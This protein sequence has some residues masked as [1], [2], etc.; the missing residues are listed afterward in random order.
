[1]GSDEQL[2]AYMALPLI[3]RLKWVDDARRF[4]LAAQT[5]ETRERMERLERLRR[6][7]AIT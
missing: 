1:M 5:S 7:D 6:G 4:T 2:R 3:E